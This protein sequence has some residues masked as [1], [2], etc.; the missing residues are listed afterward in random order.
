MNIKRRL[1]VHV[2]ILPIVFFGRWGTF[3]HILIKKKAG[4]RWGKK[5]DQNEKKPDVPQNNTIS[6]MSKT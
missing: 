2:R 1:V 4:K 3:Y 5:K 6:K